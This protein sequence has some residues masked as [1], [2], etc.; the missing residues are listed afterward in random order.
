MY[1]YEGVQELYIRF[2]VYAVYDSLDMISHAF[3]R[4][5]KI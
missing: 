5:D 2:I 4:L 3:R 1:C